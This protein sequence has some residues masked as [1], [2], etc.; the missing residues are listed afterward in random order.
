MKEPDRTARAEPSLEDR[1][2]KVKWGWGVQIPDQN[3]SQDL[4]QGDLLPMVDSVT[5]QVPTQHGMQR[6]GKN[7]PQ[8]KIRLA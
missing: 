7:I 6:A 3:R 8:H 2:R 1:M 5:S 4:G